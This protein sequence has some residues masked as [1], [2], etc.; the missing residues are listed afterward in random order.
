M[1]GG[2]SGA[3]TIANPIVASVTAA[4]A[5]VGSIAVSVTFDDISLGPGPLFINASIGCPWGVPSYDCANSGWMLQTAD[6]QWHN[7]TAALSGDSRGVVLTAAAA[8]DAGPPIAA[9]LGWGSWPILPLARVDTGA[10]AL[11]FLRSVVG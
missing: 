7:A 11:P 5:A 6:G 10:V 8:T 1:S 2:A 4:K 9:S 3:Q